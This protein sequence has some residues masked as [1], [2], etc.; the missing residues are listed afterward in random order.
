MVVLLSAAC[1]LWS[2]AG[3][4]LVMSLRGR[5]KS[6]QQRHSGTATLSVC[7]PAISSCTVV[8]SRWTA[9]RTQLRDQYGCNGDY[10]SLQS[11][12]TRLKNEVANIQ[13]EL[14][15]LK[16]KST[17]SGT[18]DSCLLFVKLSA[19][20]GM[21]IRRSEVENLLQCP[22]LNYIIIRESPVMVLKVKMSTAHCPVSSPS[23]GSGHMKLNGLVRSILP[24]LPNVPQIRDW[25]V[26]SG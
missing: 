16:C 21:S 6:E 24:L 25:E 18:T 23:T 4:Y 15:S 26:W 13:R 7:H 19:F 8:C 3:C 9:A 22:I 10:A 20:T 12:I 2:P 11:D 17:Q 14:M 1:I 5:H